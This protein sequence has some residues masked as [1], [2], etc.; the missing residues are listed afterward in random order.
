[1]D[2][3]IDVRLPDRRMVFQDL[4]ATAPRVRLAGPG[5]NDPDLQVAQLATTLVLPAQ[6]GDTRLAITGADAELRIVDNG[7][8]FHIARAGIDDTQLAELSGVW[9]NDLPGYGV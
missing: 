4:S 7:V 1:V 2:A 3:R 6:D 5:L 8:A 9:A